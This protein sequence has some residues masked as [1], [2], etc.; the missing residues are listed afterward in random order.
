[1]KR[2]RTKSDARQYAID[3]QK[4]YSRRRT[5]YGEL[6]EQQGELIHLARQFGL[7]REFRENGI[8]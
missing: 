3:W 5:S 2:I 7:V 8:I 6:A 4:R 1:M